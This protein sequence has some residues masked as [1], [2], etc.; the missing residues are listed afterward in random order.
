MFGSYGLSVTS[1]GPSNPNTEPQSLE[2]HGREALENQFQG[3]RF[4]IGITISCSLLYD[5]EENKATIANNAPGFL[6]GIHGG[7]G[8]EGGLNMPMRRNAGSAL[9]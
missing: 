4:L 3:L 8:G 6:R 5:G 7:W 2:T 9:R 1:L